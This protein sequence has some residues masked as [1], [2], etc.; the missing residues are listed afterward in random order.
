LTSIIDIP[1]SDNVQL[2][3]GVVIP[4]VCGALFGPVAGFVSGFAGNLI[5]D[6]VL[7]WGFWPFWYLGNGLMGLAV[8]LFRQ[9]DGSYTR[10][11]EGTGL[12]LSITRRLVELMGG[13][14]AVHSVLGQGSR[15]VVTLP[16]ILAE[17]GLKQPPDKYQAE[18]S[19]VPSVPV[20]PAPGTE[21][22]ITLL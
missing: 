22:T 12:G 7:G 10:Q 1:G 20:F 3:P 17:E 21:R 2:R 11:R 9:L 18:E 15:F 8:G 6:Q 19:S 16:L 14:I 5:A 4:I 13:M